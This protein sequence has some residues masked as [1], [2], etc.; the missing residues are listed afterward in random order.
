MRAKIGATW[1][2]A[3]FIVPFI[4]YIHIEPILGFYHEWFAALCGLLAASIFILPKTKLHLHIPTASVLPIGLLII[5]AL[6][7]LFGVVGYSSQGL[8]ACFS[9]ILVI[10]LMMGVEGLKNQWSLEHILT[11]ISMALMVAGLFNVFAGIAQLLAQAQFYNVWVSPSVGKQIYGNLGQRNHFTLLIML[12]LLSSLYLYR[13]KVLGPWKLGLVYILFIIALAISGSRS[14]WLYLICASI[15]T[16]VLYCRAS[17][18]ANKLLMYL[19]L[20]SL[21]AFLLF[22][23]LF[24]LQIF[25][26]VMPITTANERLVVEGAGSSGVRLDVWR[27]AIEMLIDSD[28][29]GVGYGNF[30]WSNYQKV[31]ENFNQIPPNSSLLSVH[32]VNAHNAVLHLLAELGIFWGGVLLL[33]ILWG[34]FYT[35]R[36][37]TLESWCIWSV[38]AVMLI[39]SLLE[40][41]LWYMHFLLPFAVFLT[42]LNDKNLTIKAPLVWRPLVMVSAVI[43]VVFLGELYVENAALNRLFLAQRQSGDETISKR[44]LR[45][46]MRSSV[47]LPY[48][49]QFLSKMFV[50]LGDENALRNQMIINDRLVKFW[51]T[52]RILYRRV[53]LLYMLGR[54]DESFEV[55]AAAAKVFGSQLN[56]FRR[57]LDRASKDFP[58]LITLRDSVVLLERKSGSADDADPLHQQ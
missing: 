23:E 34:Y 29:L 12:G 11:G 27:H 45:I 5:I 2:L 50:R 19:M 32:F 1:L 56:Q 57:Y 49:D 41:P 44:D 51:P 3:L 25:K 14:T 8:L 58:R 35:K 9:L 33:G 21:P 13:V 53:L 36:L 54:E 31:A 39:H 40:Y 15:L 42:L 24:S 43:G 47:L 4:P 26:E 55:L 48:S 46:A 52:S 30:A 20:V 16:I 37:E 28:L 38:L 17:A 18:S 7:T 22:Q 10:F 6:Q